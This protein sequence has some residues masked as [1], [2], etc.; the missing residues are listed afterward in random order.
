ML[1]TKKTNNIKFK[2]VKKVS[3]NQFEEILDLVANVYPKSNNFWKHLKVDFNES[4]QFFEG[5]LSNCDVITVALD[6]S[7]DDKIVGAVLGVE[8]KDGDLGPF[9]NWK[10]TPKMEPYIDMLKFMLKNADFSRTPKGKACFN[11]TLVANNNYRGLGNELLK[12]HYEFLYYV[13][14][15]KN[16]TAFISNKN[17]YTQEFI[18]GNKQRL[19]ELALQYDYKEFEWKSTKPFKGM[20][21]PPY[22]L[23]GTVVLERKFDPKKNLI[24]KL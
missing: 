14:G 11:K 4:R 19:D 21:D 22:M 1:H 12:K 7:I 6:T 10:N 18:N 20:D 24:P 3:E 9:I 13:G 17:A 23:L 2:L 5:Y 15:F 16:N 8:I